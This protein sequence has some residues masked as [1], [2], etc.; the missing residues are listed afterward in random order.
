M[1]NFWH[2]VFL[3]STGDSAC[4]EKNA[5]VKYGPILDYQFKFQNWSF[6]KKRNLSYNATKNCFLR[7]FLHYFACIR[8]VQ[9]I[10][11]P[12]S[13]GRIIR[14][15]KQMPDGWAA[16]SSVHVPRV[17]PR[18]WD[19]CLTR[20]RSGRSILWSA[21]LCLQD[22]WGPGMKAWWAVLNASHT[23]R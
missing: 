20:R 14:L 15:E 4:L 3:S 11:T 23:G 6:T 18:T 10:L 22:A 13:L 2:I 17:H 8:A 5:P 16:E 21:E 9:Y 19:A 12:R 7:L 1:N